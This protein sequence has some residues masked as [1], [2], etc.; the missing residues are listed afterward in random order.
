MRILYVAERYD[1]GRVDRGFSFEH[2]NFYESLSALGHDIEYFDISSRL[3]QHG[4]DG[5]N[6][7]LLRIAKRLHADFMF[8]CL[9]NDDL[10]PEVVGAITSET[11]TITFN[12]FCDDH[13]RFEDF[14]SRWAPRFSFVSTTAASA[15]P[16]YAA[17]GYDN[18]VKTQWAAA[19]SLY[20]PHGR[21][22]KYDVTFVGQVYGDRPSIIRNLR[23]AGLDVRTWGTGWDV[24]LWHRAAGRLPVVRRLGGAGWREQV[25]A[26]TRADQDQMLA[27]F[28]QS[29][30]NIDL[31]ASS[32]GA[33]PQIKG[34]T[35]EV[36]A[37]G[38][39]LLD[40]K[41][42]EIEEYFE[43]GKELVTYD[44]VDDLIEKTRYYLEH[45]SERV[46]IQAAGTARVHAEHTYRH[47]FED[48][49]KAIG[50]P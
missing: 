35:F 49:F 4:R 39:F 10:D 29:K 8:C 34:R 16:K 38:G 32:H 36:P 13:W 15:L 21:P 33:E 17:I 30:V 47:R 14:T 5:M 7:E 12:W 40:G 11:D 3:R 19:D 44:D 28:E 43:L 48:I 9:M 26:R 20:R 50:L 22:T 1:Y 37:C 46:A 42:A 6:A 31:Y 23:K 24:R 18:V 27:I 41:A 2:F 45:D 25:A